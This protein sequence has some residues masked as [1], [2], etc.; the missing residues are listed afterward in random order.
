MR[1]A[2]ETAERDHQRSR[3]RK[4]L[5]E[6]RKEDAERQLAEKEREEEKRKAVA[7]RL[8]VEAEEKRRDEER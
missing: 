2:L 1:H 7:E 8:T 5:I 6:K 4:V 3:S